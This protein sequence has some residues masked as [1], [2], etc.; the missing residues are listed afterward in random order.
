MM[1][2]SHGQPLG[3]KNLVWLD[4]LGPLK[5]PVKQEYDAALSLNRNLEE[6]CLVFET[7]K[8]L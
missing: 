4:E 2:K 1:V 7:T 8:C 3:F 5:P 6:N